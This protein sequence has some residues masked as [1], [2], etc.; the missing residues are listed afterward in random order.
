MV[1]FLSFRLKFGVP[2]QKWL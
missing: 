2:G 1:M